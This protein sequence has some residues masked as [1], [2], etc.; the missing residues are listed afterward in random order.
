MSLYAYRLAALA[1][2]LLLWSLFIWTKGAAYTQ[3][4]WDAQVLKEERRNTEDVIRLARAASELDAI[5][6]QTTTV[7]REKI[8]EIEKK[9]PV[10]VSEKADSKC[11]IPVGFIRLWDEPLH[12]AI[13]PTSPFL[14][15]E[16]SSG[17]ALSRIATA[18][19]LEAKERFEVNRFSLVSCQSY[20]RKVQEILNAP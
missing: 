17:V 11:D 3:N 9:V 10:Y 14:G 2:A 8:K 5:W 18:G 12:E 6:I 7:V 20:I 19:V 15:N 13:T 1:A 16:D 4:K